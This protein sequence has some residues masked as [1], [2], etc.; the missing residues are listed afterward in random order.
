VTNLPIEFKATSLDHSNSLWARWSREWF[1]MGVRVSAPFHT[2]LGPTQPPIQ[3][4]LDY[5][6]ELSSWHVVLT[7]H[8]LL[9]PRL[10][11]YLVTVYMY[12]VILC[13]FNGYDILLHPRSFTANISCVWWDMTGISTVLVLLNSL[14][15][16]L[17]EAPQ[18]ALLLTVNAI[19]DNYLKLTMR[20]PYL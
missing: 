6:W 2:D 3:W 20:R 19:H 9:P 11:S 13:Y 5:S 17:Y 8:P 15:F 12:V 1:P 18:T 7:N 10:T 4:V 16:F 14:C